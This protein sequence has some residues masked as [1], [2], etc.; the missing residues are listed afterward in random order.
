M[1]VVA[2][3]FSGAIFLILQSFSNWEQNPISTT[4]E[5]VHISEITLP[6]ITVCPPK[7]LSLNLN[8]DIMKAKE[9]Q[10]DEQLRNELYNYALYEFQ[11]IISNHMIQNLS[12]IKDQDRYYNWYYGYTQIRFSYIN[13]DDN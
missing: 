12:K 1:F 13:E 2:A 4:I 3:G 5:T 11:D 10:I 9:I 6:N 7:N 8:F